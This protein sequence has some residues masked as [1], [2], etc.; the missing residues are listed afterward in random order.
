M[1]EVIGIGTDLCAVSRMEKAIAKEHFYTRVF[2]EGDMSMAFAVI[3][4]CG[5]GPGAE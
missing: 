1:P 4:G 3:E 5:P 2:L